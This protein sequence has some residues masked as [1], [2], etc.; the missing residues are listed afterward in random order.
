MVTIEKVELCL[1]PYLFLSFVLF[2]NVIFYVY[3]YEH[4]SIEYVQKTDQ[5]PGIVWLLMLSMKNE[6]SHF[7]PF[8]RFALGYPITGSFGRIQ[9]DSW[10]D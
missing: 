5:N 2:Y 9:K 3:H 4:T 1:L 10:T 6:M 7:S 8:S